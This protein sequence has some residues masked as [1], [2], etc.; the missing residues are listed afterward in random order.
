[1]IRK[2]QTLRLFPKDITGDVIKDRQEVTINWRAGQL[3]LDE[4]TF[5]GGKDLGPD[6]FSTVLSGLVAC[7]LTTL[8][9][10]I[11]KKEWNITDIHCAVNMVQQTEP[12]RTSIFRTLSFG[13]PVTDAQK[14]RL[15]WIAKNCPVARLLEGEINIDTRLSDDPTVS[16]GMGNYPPSDEASADAAEKYTAQ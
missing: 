9:M 6:P 1:M 13:Q 8:R 12:F 16:A 15:L 2:K 5:N 14:E 7:T 10:Y 4:P 11:K 3:I